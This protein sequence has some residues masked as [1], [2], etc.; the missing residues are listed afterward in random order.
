MTY[1]RIRTSQSRADSFFV[2]H[3]YY[4]SMVFAHIYLSTLWTGHKARKYRRP[5]TISTSSK[6]I[7]GSSRHHRNFTRDTS[8]MQAQTA[9]A[10]S[11]GNGASGTVAPLATFT[12]FPR[13]PLELRRQIVRIAALETPIVAAE[14]GRV[15]D[16]NGNRS[17]YLLVPIRAST[18]LLRVNNEARA[19]CQTVLTAHHEPQ[20]G[21]PKLYLNERTGILWCINFDDMTFTHKFDALIPEMSNGEVPKIRTLATGWEMWPKLLSRGGKEYSLMAI[22][23][24]MRKLGIEEVLIVTKPSAK[25]STPWEYSDIEFRDAQ[26]IDPANEP[27][28]WK[29]LRESLTVPTVSV[30]NIEKALVEY[31]QRI[32]NACLERIEHELAS[33]YSI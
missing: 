7:R 26:E 31:I 9:T 25:F 1:S 28:H 29:M 24:N 33:K 11:Q 18:S 12:P 20:S 10:S 21:E 27:I 23:R 6:S 17:E 14:I 15:N 3:I 19:E 8:N 22:I 30:R 16:K 2:A 4:A 5:K 13:L 32:R